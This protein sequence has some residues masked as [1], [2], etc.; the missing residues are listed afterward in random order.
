[1]ERWAKYDTESNAI[2]SLEKAAL[3]LKTVK[4]NPEDWKW[5]VICMFSSLYGF[6]IQVA[7]GSDDSSVIKVAKNGHSR[8]ISFGEALKDCK[9]SIGARTALVTTEHEDWAID[10]IQN[11]FR[12]KFE[13]YNPGSWSIEVSGFPVI[14]YHILNV[15]RR[16][17]L[18]HNFY[19]HIS[20]EQRESLEYVLDECEYI[21]G[22][23]KS[24]YAS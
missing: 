8:L 12:N 5:V 21:N 19:S 22:K 2:D 1:M 9:R 13:H 4:D 17:S 6:A 20:E 11:Q 16:L 15:I 24:L 18:V 10:N 23:L 14:I 7:K 3:F